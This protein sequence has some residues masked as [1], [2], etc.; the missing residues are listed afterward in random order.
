[1]ILGTHITGSQVLDE[2]DGL[3][4]AG[5][6]SEVESSSR[7]RLPF[8]NLATSLSESGFQNIA[9]RAPGVGVPKGLE[10][11]FGSV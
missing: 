8:G 9:R 6:G 2:M 3:S 11:G 5:G 1:M 7:A 10:V 4:V